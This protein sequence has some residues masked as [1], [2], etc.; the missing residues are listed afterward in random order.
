MNNE[1]PET[2][3]R[4]EIPPT[5]ERRHRRRRFGFMKLAVLVGVGTLVAATF[6]SPAAEAWGRRG[7][8]GHGGPGGHPSLSDAMVLEHARGGVDRLIGRVDGTDAQR[9]ALEPIID[10]T[11]AELL[12]IRAQGKVLKAELHEA[13]ARGDLDRAEL[14]VVRRKGLALADLASAKVFDTLLEVSEVL[15]PE[16]RAELTED[17]RRMEKWSR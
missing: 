7:S 2:Q 14:E 6:Y 3:D 8:W 16:Q 9:E 4:Q 10:Q 5:S 1:N 15:T 13:M 12:A 17:L 11:V